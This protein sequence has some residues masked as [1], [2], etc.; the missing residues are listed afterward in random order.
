MIVATATGS[1]AYALS[2]GGPILAPETGGLLVVP[3]APH[4]LCERS[5]LTAPSD[6]VDIAVS[7]DSRSHAC[8]TVDGDEIPFEAPPTRIVASRHENDVLLA[9]VDESDFY[10]ALAREFYGA[11]DRAPGSF[12]TSMLHLMQHRPTLLALQA[13]RA[14]MWVTLALPVIRMMKGHW[15]ETALAVALLFGVVF[16]IQLLVP[17]PWMPKTL[18]MLH[19]LETSTSNSIFGFL[20]GWLLLTPIDPGRPFRPES[21]LAKGSGE[22]GW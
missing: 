12:L 5:I 13:L 17:N 15:A 1:T 16:S 14:L 20:V 18:R 8:I 3:V 11:S 6:T 9:R 10:S 22:K 7:T 21:E 2:A 19:L 4:T